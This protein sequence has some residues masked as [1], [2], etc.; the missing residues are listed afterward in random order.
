[1]SDPC[2]FAGTVLV[3]LSVLDVVIE[4]VAIAGKGVK[5]GSVII[6]QGLGRLVE[7]SRGIYVVEGRGR[8]WWLIPLHMEG[9]P[10]PVATAAPAQH[11]SSSQTE[12]GRG[13][14]EIHGQANLVLHPAGEE[15]V[16]E[17]HD[18]IVGGPGH[19][20]QAEQAGTEKTNPPA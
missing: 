13:V 10:R 6:L 5:W 15:G 20:D 16:V 7:W 12:A 8:W 17:L 2:G 1:M 19:G 3:F 9:T 11:Q 14:A 18:D 4:P